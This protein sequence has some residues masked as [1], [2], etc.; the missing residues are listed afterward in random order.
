MTHPS[1][2]D[3]SSLG[4]SPEVLK[5]LAAKGITT[6]SPIQHSAIPHALKGDDV[7]G[8]AQT[9][10]GKTFAFG[11]PLLERLHKDGKRALIVLPTR[12]LAQQV[13]ESLLPIARHF[14][15]GIAVFIGGAS[16][17]R[18]RMML[19]MNP[20]V[21][22][23]TPGRLI[24]HLQQRTVTLKEVSILVLDEADRMLDMGFAP[25]IKKILQAVPAE[26]QTL[27]FSATMPAAIGK[28]AA[29]HMRTPVRVE[30]APP[31]TSASQVEQHAII[32]PK[33]EKTN[34]LHSLLSETE[35]TALVFV[36]TKHN[37]KKLTTTLK[38]MGHSVAE[39]H[40]NRSLAQRKEALGGFKTGKYK[41]L[42]ATDI[43]ARGIDVVG[44]ELVINFDLPDNP[45]DY[46]HRIGRT[47]RAGKAGQSMSFVTPDQ[48]GDLKIIE[49]LIRKSVNVSEHPSVAGMK[50]AEPSRPSRRPPSRGRRSFRRR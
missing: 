17:H 4:L 5:L 34:M 20:R 8:I 47:G 22:I 10:T 18:Q 41:V 16:M 6:P 25:Q 45:E 37:A 28:I 38:T 30:V 48:R 13:E 44:L 9:G 23:A 39:I 21:L 7:I 15:I 49:R 1:P 42:V 35:G 50:Y 3:F 12:E 29:E 43:A 36:R 19:K 11:L 14:K 32:V 46:V 24:D 26:R 31:G 33:T 27:L 2:S 40:S